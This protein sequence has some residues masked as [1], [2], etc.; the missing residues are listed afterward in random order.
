MPI[1]QRDKIIAPKKGGLGSNKS[2]FD[3]LNE[4]AA[5]K[6]K[7]RNLDLNDD[8]PPMLDEDST[9]SNDPLSCDVTIKRPA[10]TFRDLLSPSPEEEDPKPKKT[11]A[12]TSTTM[13]KLGG[14]GL[15]SKFVPPRKIASQDPP[16]STPLSTTE[17]LKAKAEAKASGFSAPRDTKPKLL[18]STAEIDDGE[19]ELGPRKPKAAYKKYGAS[20]TVAGRGRMGPWILM[21]QG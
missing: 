6:T 3:K 13:R 1:P 12:S 21:M 11:T 16:R 9:L 17:K 20:R 15:T 7:A 2:V 5:K 19:E 18:A 10:T 14:G 8:D 4:E